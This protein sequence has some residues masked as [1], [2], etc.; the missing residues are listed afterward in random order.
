M[1]WRMLWEWPGIAGCIGNLC[2][3][4]PWN[5]QLHWDFG[6][7]CVCGLTLELKDALASCLGSGPRVA[8]YVESQSQEHPVQ[9]END[10]RKR[11]TTNKNDEN[12][13]SWGG[14]AY[15]YIYIYICIPRGSIHVVSATISG[16]RID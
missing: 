15:I 4:C 6:F 11:G 1:H 8:R 16:F 5:G 10:N 7:D 2:G 9:G 14:R 12:G 13:S 3:D